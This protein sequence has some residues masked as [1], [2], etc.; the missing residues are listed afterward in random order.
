MLSITRYPNDAI[1]LIGPNGET[2]QIYYVMHRGAQVRLA[3]DAPKEFKIIRKD[4]DES[5]ADAHKRLS[6]KVS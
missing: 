5:L 1:V 2:I 6:E 4:S 3:I